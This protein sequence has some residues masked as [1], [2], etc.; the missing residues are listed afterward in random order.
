MARQL[1]DVQPR[2]RLE[3]APN[4][5]QNLREDEAHHG[6]STRHVH[7]T[8]CETRQTH[9]NN[10]YGR[11]I[12]GRRRFHEPQLLEPAVWSWGARRVVVGSPPCDRGEPAV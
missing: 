6:S 2:P 7:T 11:G 1:W 9:N 12:G 10:T 5:L 3:I 4:T 8:R